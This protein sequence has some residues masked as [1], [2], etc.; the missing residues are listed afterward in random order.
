MRTSHPVLDKLYGGRKEGKEF[1]DACE[2][3]GKGKS[4][5]GKMEAKQWEEMKATVEYALEHDAK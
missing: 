4:A 5:D 2:A 1:V 3:I